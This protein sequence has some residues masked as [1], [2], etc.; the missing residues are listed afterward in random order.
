MQSD[1]TEK[2]VVTAA[3]KKNAK[4]IKKNPNYIVKLQQKN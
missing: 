3:R 4:K 2:K 1:H